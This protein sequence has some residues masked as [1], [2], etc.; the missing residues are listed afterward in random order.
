MNRLHKITI[1]IILFILLG[2]GAAFLSMINISQNTQ[3]I[4]S[5]PTAEAN[6]T[7]PQKQ[8]VKTFVLIYPVAH[9]FFETVTKN[10]EQAAEEFGVEV[11]IRAPEEPT[12]EQQVKLMEYYIS[13]NVDGI[14][15]GPSDAAALTPFINKAVAA[16][17]PVICFDTDAPNSDRLAY[18]G[19]D[20]FLAGTHLGNVLTDY[21]NKKGKILISTGLDSM[22][23]LN[24]RIEGI[25]SIIEQYPEMEIVD[26]RSSEG[27]PA[28]THRNIEAMIE[29]HPDFDALIGTDSLA[30]PA[31]VMIWKAK[32]LDE[33]VITFDNMPENLAGIEN[34]QITSVIS[35]KQFIWG[36]EI[37]KYLIRASEGEEI[38][39][40][41]NTGTVEITKD[42]VHEFID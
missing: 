30:G 7:D 29:E 27:V 31:A 40:T 17:I 33:I 34:G 5:K 36:N 10:A 32:G 2:G 3:P 28:Q 16:G 22:L 38:P 23:N 41:V 11:I 8:P 24:S 6:L 39:L 19:T 14:A 42:N 12:V 20:N 9:P 37:L 35:Q 1:L 18:I 21:L 25:Q 26:I 15:I 4:E 13:R